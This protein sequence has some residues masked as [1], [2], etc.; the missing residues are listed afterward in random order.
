MLPL[1]PIRHGENLYL[2]ALRLTVMWQS[3]AKGSM[4]TA[5][6]LE[7]I[8]KACYWASAK[9]ANSVVRESDSRLAISLKLESVRRSANSVAHQVA[10]MAVKGSLAP[11]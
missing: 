5:A 1:L 11:N 7:V 4:A 8:R 3:Q 9:N 2:A 10:A 6:M